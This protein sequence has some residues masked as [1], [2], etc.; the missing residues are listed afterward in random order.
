MPRTK[1]VD[2]K[3]SNK[4]EEFDEVEENVEHEEND[5]ELD[6]DDDLELDEEDNNNDSEDNNDSDD[7]ED[8][9]DNEDTDN[10]TDNEDTE[11]KV[12]NKKKQAKKVKDE[13][14]DDEDIE[15]EDDDDYND[16]DDIEEDD[17]EYMTEEYEETE[18]EQKMIQS[19]EKSMIQKIKTPDHNFNKT[20][21]VIKKEDR[22][23]RPI[24]TKYEYIRCLG[25]RTQQITLG[26]KVMLSNEAELRERYTPK[27]IAEIE[28]REK[29]CPLIVVRPLPNNKE[30]HWS[31]N[32]LEFLA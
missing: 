3:T 22:I 16:D 31:I 28:I 2:K 18:E 8:T 1:K 26:A 12:T 15:D 25:E 32:E 10:D 23:S 6:N 27:E 4:E 11:D 24:L 7:M 17:E 5:D 19:K 30:E 13:D 29:V 9:E 20:V 21:E 14:S